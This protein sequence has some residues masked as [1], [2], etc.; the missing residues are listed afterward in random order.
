MGSINRVKIK[1]EKNE[2]LIDFFE[3]LEEEDDVQNI[4]SNADFA[5]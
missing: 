4:Y 3:N 1:N 2:D 5:K